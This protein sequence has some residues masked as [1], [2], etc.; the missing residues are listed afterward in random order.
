MKQEFK[1]QLQH[2]IRLEIAYLITF[3]FGMSIKLKI[4]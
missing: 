2:V 1:L 4:P 3:Q